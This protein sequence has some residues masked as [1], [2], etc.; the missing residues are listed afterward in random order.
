M[1]DSILP[2]Q[3]LERSVEMIERLILQSS[4]GLS[5]ATFRI[6]NRVIL[7]VGGVHHE[8][9]VW[10]D[11]DHGRGYDSIFIFECKNWKG[12][13]KVGKNDIIVF[14]EKIKAAG[15][16]WPAIKLGLK[17]QLVEKN[18]E[19]GQ[20]KK[21]KRAFAWFSDDSGGSIA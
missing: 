17:L 13:R 7:A 5:E 6:R 14:S 12:N 1:A 11:I 3:D 15:N 18:L 8:V 20:H 21:F 10:V 2:G 16:T 4:S 9:D 19:L